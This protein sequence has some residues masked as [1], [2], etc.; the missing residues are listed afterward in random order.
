MDT[1]RGP[2]RLDTLC[3]DI[4]FHLALCLTLDDLLSFSIVCARLIS[5]VDN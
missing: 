5:T 2:V 4:I 3:D 1:N